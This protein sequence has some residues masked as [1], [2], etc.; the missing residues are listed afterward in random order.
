MISKL[1]G[2]ASYSPSFGLAKLSEVGSQVA[3]TFGHPSNSY[4]NGDLYKRQNLFDDSAL[5]NEIQSGQSFTKLCD[6]YGCT[7][8]AMAN[9][10]FIN[11]QIIGKKSAKALNLVPSDELQKGLTK[12]YYANYD[13]PELSKRN[14]KALL[15]LLKSTMAPDEYVKNIGLLEEGVCK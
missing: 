11:S 9:A 15:K 5:A 1:S 2:A 10:A 13:N 4:V 3:A 14:T 7:K 6:D 8:F 12:L